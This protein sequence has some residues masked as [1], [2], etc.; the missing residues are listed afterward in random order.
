MNLEKRL[1]PS[2]AER[3][4]R[5]SLKAKRIA[6]RGED[7][8]VAYL[9]TNSYRLLARNYRAGRAG[10][11]DIVVMDENGVLVFVESKD[12]YN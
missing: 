8:A 2:Q 10:E 7:L 5:K 9:E 6:T 11:I 4:H 12:S 1:Y 3:R